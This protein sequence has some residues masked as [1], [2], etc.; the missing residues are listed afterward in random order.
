MP[1]GEYLAMIVD[2]EMKQTKSGSG[3]Y[4]NVALEIVDGEHKGRR[5][6]DRLNLR[7]QNETAVKIA[8]ASLSAI[9]HAVN[10]MRP[11]DSA[12]LHGKPMLVRVALEER[13]DK[14]GS[15]RNEVR[16]YQAANGAARP[17]PAVT[18]QASRPAAARASAP[19]ASTPPWKK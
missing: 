7:N 11:R 15:W 13:D 9:C 3:E 17:Q 19:A 8:Q 4:L 6:W 2:T 18:P 1:A 14:P 5:L 12:E 10:V 16:G